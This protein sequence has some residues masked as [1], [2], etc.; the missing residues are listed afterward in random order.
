M[1]DMDEV[2]RCGDDVA[3]DVD[4]STGN[5]LHYINLMST[6]PAEL[7]RWSALFPSQRKL[8][9]F[10]LHFQRLRSASENLGAIRWGISVLAA[11]VYDALLQPGPS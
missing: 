5:T 1:W 3:G 4:D 2:L 11:P 10:E 8:H 7:M 6:E 9:R